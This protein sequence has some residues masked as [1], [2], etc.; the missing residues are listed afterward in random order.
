MLEISLP[1]NCCTNLRPVITTPGSRRVTFPDATAACSPVYLY[2]I[3]GHVAASRRTP[4]LPLEQHGLVTSLSSAVTSRSASPG[5]TSDRH[6]P[7]SRNCPDIAGSE[8]R[9]DQG[10]SP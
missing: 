7:R 4:T 9:L 6:P 5:G 8:V 2:R 3:S 10:E 1:D